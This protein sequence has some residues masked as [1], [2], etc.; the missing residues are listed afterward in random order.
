MSAPVRTRK[1]VGRRTAWDVPIHRQ[2]T[3]VASAGRAPGCRHYHAWFSYMNGV[4]CPA[5]PGRSG[6]GRLLVALDGRWR[7]RGRHRA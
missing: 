6:C 1:V 7:Y 4:E 3:M 2:P 5:G